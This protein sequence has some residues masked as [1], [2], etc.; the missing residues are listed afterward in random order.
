MKMITSNKIISLT[1]LMFALLFS[2]S[3]RAMLFSEDFE[4]GNLSQW[5][6]STSSPTATDNAIIETLNFT[7]PN[8]PT[9]AVRFKSLGEGGLQGFHLFSSTLF[10]AGS[11]HIEFDYTGTCN[12]TDCGGV[13]G[14][15]PDNSGTGITTLAASTS[16]FGGSVELNSNNNWVSHSFDFVAT[17]DFRLALGNLNIGAGGLAGAGLSYF[18]NIQLTAAVPVPAAV[19]FLGSGLIGLFSFRRK[20]KV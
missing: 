3:S 8:N 1:A 16:G 4:A 5:T 14:Y 2:T 15:G 20:E 10:S 18:D 6:G 7:D 19:W 9:N 13:F 12:S 11:Y 17:Q